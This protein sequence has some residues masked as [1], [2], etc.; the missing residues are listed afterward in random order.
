MSTGQAFFAEL[1][2]RRSP[3]LDAI[4]A[5]NTGLPAR[6]VPSAL[7]PDAAPLERF[8]RETGHAAPFARRLPLL[9]DGAEAVWIADFSEPRHRLALLPPA[10]LEKLALWHGLVA[11]RP[12]VTGVIDREGVRALRAELGEEAYAFALR[13]SSLLA[14]AGS[15]PPPPKDEPLVRRVIRT[16]RTAV[17]ACLADAPPLV[18]TKLAYT[19]ESEFAALLAGPRGTGKPGGLDPA[20]VWPLLRTLAEKEI[21]PSWQPCFI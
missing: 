1:L 19:L 17:A 3:L 21:V 6:I 9:V 7:A 5:F 4:V 16:G 10:A 11:H 13:R 8:L 2:R 14:G 20:S 18:R 12:E 15:A